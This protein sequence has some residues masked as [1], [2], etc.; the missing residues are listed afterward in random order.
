M[1]ARNNNGSRCG[2][3][4]AEVLIAAAIGAAV[5]TAAAIGFAV[6][7]GAS[8]RGG[9]VDVQLPGNTYANLYGNN[10]DYVTVWPNPNYSEAAKARA[11]RDKLM[12]D[13]SAST[14]VFCLGRNGTW[15]N[16]RP[17]SVEFPGTTDL[18]NFSTPTAFRQ[19]L[20]T[21]NV[22]GASGFATNQSGVSSATNMTVFV[23]GGLASSDFS[24][25]ANNSLRLVATYELDFV[26][27]TSPAG[28]Y[29]SVRRYDPDEGNVPTDFYHCFYP[30]E[31]NGSDGF[32]PL[33]V[34]FGRQG[35]GGVYDI[36]PNQPFN[37][38]WWPDPL[39]SQL[40]GAAV[41]A[42]GG[43]PLRSAYSNMAGRTSL[44]SVVP[45]FPGQ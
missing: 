10:A 1:K 12:E 26:P 41:P 21:N 33:R 40:G 11:L 24:T 14:A 6:V 18:R 42:A 29:A 7:S 37:F 44:F 28:I 35:L 45:A 17:G 3:T 31:A 34:Y 36:A 39:V 23:V 22:P 16:A 9:R 4:L 27:A 38:L 19:F 8:L 15:T 2:F 13:V 30:D 32:R 25:N 20:V 5:I 43:S